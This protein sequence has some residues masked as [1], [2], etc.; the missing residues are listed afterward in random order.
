MKR[1]EEIEY[2]MMEW[3]AKAWEEMEGKEIDVMKNRT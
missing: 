1:L 3:N 2:K